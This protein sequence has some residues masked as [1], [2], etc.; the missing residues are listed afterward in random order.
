MS[1]CSR[2]LRGVALSA[3]ILVPAVAYADTDGAVGAVASVTINETS[4]DDYATE[5][6]NVYV[7][8][9]QTSRKYQWGGQA[10][11]GKNLSEAN[12]AM[13]VEALRGRADIQMVPSY[14][15]GAGNVRCLVGFRLQPAPSGSGTP[16]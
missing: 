8:E 10:C 13:L 1:L 15:T 3:V 11:N 14:K 7:N 12:I 5:R 16:S 2:V 6:G 9:G 4:S